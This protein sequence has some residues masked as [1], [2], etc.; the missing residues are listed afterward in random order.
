ME[1]KERMDEFRE[2]KNL[3]D[4]AFEKII[5]SSNGNWRKAKTVS[6]DVL[7]GFL[8]SFPE[9]SAEWL[10]RGK[11]TMT[12]SGDEQ[13]PCNEKLLSLC[14]SLVN[15]YQQRDEVMSQLVSMVKRMD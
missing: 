6:E 3:S 10:L 11:G 12:T 15:N 13:L 1:I 9:V 14:K 8:E 4:K 2:A 5:G 7:L